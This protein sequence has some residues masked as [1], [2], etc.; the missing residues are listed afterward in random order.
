MRRLLGP[1]GV[2]AR[3]G[4]TGM[5]QADHA[6]LVGQGF[7]RFAFS[8]RPKRYYPRGPQRRHRR[9]EVAIACG[10]QR[11]HRRPG[12]LV[13]GDVAAGVAQEGERAIVEHEVFGEEPVRRP[14]SLGEQP[15]EARARDLAPRA[16]KTEHRPCR[17]L[18]RWRLHAVGD[19]EPVGDRPHVPEGDPRLHH[20]ERAGIHA[21]EDGTDALVRIG[22]DVAPVRG[23]RVSQRVVDAC[24]RGTERRHFTGRSQLLRGGE[25]PL[26]RSLCHA[27][28]P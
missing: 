12:E 15:P 25:Q 19:A 26:R 9:A 1:T 27:G 6:L 24:D 7:P 23:V 14:E 20:P 4:R 2:R 11:S 3:V 17:V 5:E 22:G 16:G 10:E 28:P 18:A 21:H 8:V 13:R